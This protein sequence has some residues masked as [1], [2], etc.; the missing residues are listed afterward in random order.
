LVVEDLLCG[1]E[2]ILKGKVTSNFIVTEFS[3]VQKEIAENIN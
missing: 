1:Y 3:I 2:N